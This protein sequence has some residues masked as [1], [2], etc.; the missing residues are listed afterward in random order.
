MDAP[1]VE[2]RIW[3]V[4][5]KPVAYREA[6][7][8]LAADDG[9]FW[10]TKDSE[11]ALR[12]ERKVDARDVGNALRHMPGYRRDARGTFA[13]HVLVDYISED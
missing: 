12:F 10:W 8:Y 5:K 13:K 4:V 1:V 11:R 2:R 6:E 7:S 9:G 3:V